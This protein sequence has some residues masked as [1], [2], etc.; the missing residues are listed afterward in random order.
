LVSGVGH[1][2][3]FRTTAEKLG[4]TVLDESAYPDHHWYSP[5]DVAMLQAR[6]ADLKAELVLTTEKDAG[7]IRP[8]LRHD[9]GRWWAA[10]LGVEWLT[11]EA[12]MRKT[13]T[14]VRS[15]AERGAGV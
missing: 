7:K 12:D 4:V 5:G 13:V 3:S 10:R 6:A 14:E 9:D 1:P 2:A 11:G 15:T 8:H